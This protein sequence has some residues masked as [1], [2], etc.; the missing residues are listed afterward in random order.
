MRE[1]PIEEGIEETRKL[2][3]ETNNKATFKLCVVYL[4][5][6]QIQFNYTVRNRILLT[7]RVNNIYAMCKS[8]HKPQRYKIQATRAI[9]LIKISCFK[10][11]Q[12][13]YNC[14][15]HNLITCH[16]NMKLEE[17][18][19]GSCVT[20]HLKMREYQ[21]GRDSCFRPIREFHIKTFTRNRRREDDEAFYIF[22]VH[23]PPGP[24]SSLSL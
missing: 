18:L 24:H 9:R 13:N 11:A 23:L 4:A 14:K 5:Q 1:V 2:G 19:R 16:V 17:L 21:L 12:L 22:V 10:Y 7:C 8:H 3:E 15:L 6:K 20:S